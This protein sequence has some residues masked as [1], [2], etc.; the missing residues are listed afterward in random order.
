MYTAIVAYAVSTRYIYIYIVSIALREIRVRG[1][2]S[3]DNNLQNII[4]RENN[5]GRGREG[6]PLSAFV[7]YLIERRE[8]VCGSRGINRSTVSRIYTYTY[9]KTNVYIVSIIKNDVCYWP[10]VVH[11]Y[12]NNQ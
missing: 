1:E 4:R 3:I 8:R 12:T 6:K 7:G 10:L 5:G 11:V 2:L 9:E